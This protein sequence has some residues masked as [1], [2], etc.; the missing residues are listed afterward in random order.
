MSKTLH[1]WCLL[2]NLSSHCWDHSQTI[3]S[4]H[5]NSLARVNLCQNHN[6]FCCRIF[7]RHSTRTTWGSNPRYIF[8]KVTCSSKIFVPIP[9][10]IHKKRQTKKMSWSLILTLQIGS[11]FPEPQ[12]FLPFFCQ[13]WTYTLLHHSELPGSRH[14]VWIHLVHVQWWWHTSHSL[15]ILTSE[16]VIL[17]Q[18]LGMFQRFAPVRQSHGAALHNPWQDAYYLAEK[19]RK[20]RWIAATFWD[21]SPAIQLYDRKILQNSMGRLHMEWAWIWSIS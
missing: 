18:H 19:S 17:K 2:T 1:W 16:V 6:K 5:G 9:K 12:P 21:G 11:M 13:G 10:A 20:R 4:F 3:P 14:H 7:V 15:S 8:Q